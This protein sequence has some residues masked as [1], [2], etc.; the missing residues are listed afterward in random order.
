MIVAGPM[1]L[2][3]LYTVNVMGMIYWALLF[4]SS[5]SKRRELAG[6]ALEESYAFSAAAYESAQPT[7]ARRKSRWASRSA[8]KKAA[9]ARREQENIDSI[10]EK[11]HAHGM[12]SLNWMER[13][14]LCKATERQR[15]K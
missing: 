7:S 10:L 8:V 5:Y 4:A 13:R 6:G 15:S 14:A 1:C 11:V 3:S 12:Q 2:Y 9:A